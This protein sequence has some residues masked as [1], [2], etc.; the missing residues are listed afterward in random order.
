[1]TYSNQVPGKTVKM[2]LTE[3]RL[4]IFSLNITTHATA[5]SYSG[6][7]YQKNSQGEEE[8]LGNKGQNA[9]EMLLRKKSS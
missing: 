2:L 7:M 1:M 5:S 6:H 8:N 9:L 3:R 4:A